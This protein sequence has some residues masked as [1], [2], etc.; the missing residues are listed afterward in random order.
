MRADRWKESHPEAIREY[1][2]EERR[3]AADRRQAR[4]ARRRLEAALKQTR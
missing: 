3:D 2:I 4:R 1:R